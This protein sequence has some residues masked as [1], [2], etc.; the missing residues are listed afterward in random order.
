MFVVYD[1]YLNV[2]IDLKNNCFE[3]VFG[4]VVVIGKWLKN[5]LDYVIMDECV[6]DFDYYGKGLGIVV[7]KGN[8]V[9]L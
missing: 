8:D 6:S 2:F 3:G 1:S 4:D 5:N 9:L 7:C